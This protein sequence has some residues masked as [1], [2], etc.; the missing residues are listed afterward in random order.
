MFD[1]MSQQKRIII[2]VVLSLLFF[3]VYDFIVPKPV[4]NKPVANTNNTSEVIEKKLDLDIKDKSKENVIATISD[5]HFNVLINDRGEIISYELKDKKFLKDDS[6]GI[7]LVDKNALLFPL[8]INFYDSEFNDLFNKTPFVAN[9]DMLKTNEELVLTKNINDIVVTKV[10]KFKDNGFYEVKVNFSDNKDRDYVITPGQRPNV[11]ADSYTVH[12]AMLYKNDDT[13]VDYEDGNIKANVQEVEENIMISAFSDRYYTST[14]YNLDKPYKVIL[15]NLNGLSVG[16]IVAK[17]NEIFNGYIGPKE[18]KVLEKVDSRLTNVVEYGWFTFIAKPMFSFL[19]FLHS[20]I[21][22]WGW[23]IV[24]LTIIIRIILFPLTYKSMV[25]MQKL[26]VLAPKI[27][28]IQEK[29]KGDAQKMQMHMMELYKKHKANPLGGCLPILIQIPIFFAIYRVLLN[30][31]ELKAAPWALWI[32]DLALHDPYY[33]LPI[34]MGVTMF[35]QQIIT[36]MT[37]QDPT[38]AKIIKFLPVVFVFFF[39]SFPAGL[40]LYW[41]VNNTFSLAQQ[42]FINKIFAK[43][44]AKNE[45]N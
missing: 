12:G 19:S 25:S 40:T 39:I 20:H 41:C 26:K 28:E 35:L 27:K 17:G 10:I 8:A 6:E 23:A 21:N 29:Y 3:I 42:W 5:E 44:E 16:Y 18:H 33:V 24:V 1:N 22:N 11:I 7:N 30:A 32:N 45:N 38:Q 2:A 37:I 15:K 36:P 34:Y 4:V 31:I 43:K 13:K 14:F 9:K